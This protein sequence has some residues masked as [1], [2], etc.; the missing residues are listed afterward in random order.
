MGHSAVPSPMLTEMTLG[1]G[2]LLFSNDPGE[3]GIGVSLPSD[4]D[5]GGGFGWRGDT[6]DDIASSSIFMETR[7]PL[8]SLPLSMYLELG[9]IL[10][11][12][13]DDPWAGA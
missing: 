9:M 13:G 3:G 7:G 1:I 6:R 5:R 11:E 4:G 2:V 10:A 12:G 8:A